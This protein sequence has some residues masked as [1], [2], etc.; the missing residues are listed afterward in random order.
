MKSAGKPQSLAGLPH[1]RQWCV[2]A[3]HG[4]SSG[5][6]MGACCAGVAGQSSN[7]QRERCLPIHIRMACQHV[8]CHTQCASIPDSPP[9]PT[10]IVPAERMGCVRCDTNYFCHPACG[11]NALVQNDRVG[12]ISRLRHDAQNAMRRIFNHYPGEGFGVGAPVFRRSDQSA[13]R[14]WQA[15]PSPISHFSPAR[16][17]QGKQRDGRCLFS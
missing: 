11:C 8:R 15:H 13:S 4:L 6:C 9:R 10:N 17:R 3:G 16:V 5:R 12:S 7:P 1:A 14:L 2:L